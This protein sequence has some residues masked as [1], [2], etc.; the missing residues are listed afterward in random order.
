MFHLLA[1]SKLNHRACDEKGKSFSIWPES[2][3]GICSNPV[4]LSE[5]DNKMIYFCVT[6]DKEAEENLEKLNHLAKII[7]V[8]KVRSVQLA[9]PAALMTFI[10]LIL[11]FGTTLSDAQRLLRLCTEQLFLLVLP[12]SYG[13]LEIEFG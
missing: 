8:R 2:G 7:Q 9:L 6:K 4:A 10:F 13:L 5:I 1:P 12:E 11:G 3:S